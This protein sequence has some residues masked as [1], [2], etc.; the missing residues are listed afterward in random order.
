MT[1][2][3]T[4]IGIRTA[5]DV[6]MASVVGSG[7]E[8]TVVLEAVT[9]TTHNGDSLQDTN[10]A[11]NSFLITDG[12][13]TDTLTV[14][15]STG[16]GSGPDHT[17]GTLQATTTSYY[18]TVSGWA[19]GMDYEADDLYPLGTGNAATGH[20]MDDGAIEEDNFIVSSAS[21]GA[22][23]LTAPADE[24]HDGVPG[25]GA[26]IEAN[27]SAI[28]ILQ[29]NS[30]PTNN[31]AEVSWIELDGNDY[32]INNGLEQKR[33]RVTAPDFHHL[34]VYD[35]GQRW[36]GAGI[37]QK[38]GIGGSLRCTRC[39][40]WK[41]D[42]AV[43]HNSE[44]QYGISTA[45]ADSTHL[46][47]ILNCTVWSITQEY[48]LKNG[49]GISTYDHANKV[50]KNNVIIDCNIDLD[51]DSPSV[52]TSYDYNCTSDTTSSGSNSLASKTAADNFV[53][54]APVDL[55]LK[56]GADCIDEGVDLGT[57]YEAVELDID[58]R[59]VDAEGDTWDIGAHE[60]VVVA[61]F[62]AAW[63]RCANVLIGSKIGD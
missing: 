20:L 30:G 27:S 54:I 31:F 62:K 9:T 16:T 17:S 39:M 24:R 21:V 47:E 32:A 10:A 55:H 25:T 35:G 26:R 50:V 43:D 63:A 44:N 22:I 11:G 58:N 61:A 42:Y 12:A 13:G 18:S 45:N 48:A 41:W 60:F 15:D 28:R 2:I 23:T 7:P 4:T 37:T 36:G 29:V 34:L 3:I 14:I 6:T 52:T 51:L 49:Y 57:T 53:G 40:V 8:Y 59:D 19:S 1:E 56:S 46:G 33:S 38:A 5:E